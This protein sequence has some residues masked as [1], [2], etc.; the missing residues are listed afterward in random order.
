MSVEDLPTLM[1][2]FWLKTDAA[3]A[4]NILSPEENV[5]S[6]RIFRTE[7]SSRSRLTCCQTR[8]SSAN[9]VVRISSAARQSDARLQFLYLLIYIHWQIPRSNGLV[10]IPFRRHWQR[11]RGADSGGVEPSS[12]FSS[13]VVTPSS[14]MSVSSYELHSS[15]ALIQAPLNRLTTVLTILRC[16][17]PQMFFHMPARYEPREVHRTL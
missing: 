9:A 5:P 8:P 2:C 14:G 15:I 6:P 7:I 12:T 16:K 3:I 13:I 10:P 1:R 17:S 11:L 4:S